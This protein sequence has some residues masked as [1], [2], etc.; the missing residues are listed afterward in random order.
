MGD[1]EIHVGYKMKGKIMGFPGRMIQKF[2]TVI[3]NSKFLLAVM[4]NVFFL[5]LVLLFCDM[6]YEVSD[7]FIMSTIM[8]GVY[9]ECPNPHMIFVNIVLGYFLMPIYKVFPGISWYFV[10]Q[11][12]IIFLSSIVVSFILLEKVEKVKAALLS[13]MLILFFVNDMYILMQ[14]TK[15]AMFAIMSGSWLF[16]DTLLDRK[17]VV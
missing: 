15:T 13:I 10:L 16:L 17:S 5:L 14:F 3:S 11:I 12:I 1:S 2:K 6:K 8:S 9:G 7:D 4:I